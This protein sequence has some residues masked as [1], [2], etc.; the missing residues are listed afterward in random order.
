MAGLRFLEGV[1]GRV[2]T[3]FSI[4]KKLLR[5]SPAPSS[6][7]ALSLVTLPADV[8][9]MIL[10]L[11][12]DPWVCE[13]ERE[14]YDH[15]ICKGRFLLPLSESC[16]YMRR[17]TLP[18]IFREVYNWD[19]QDGSVW[20]ETLWSF[21]LTVHIRDRSMRDPG[22]ITLSTAMFCAL[23][24]MPSLTK[25]TLRL[26][27]AISPEL[28]L[29]LS[30]AP[31][32]TF[33]DIHQVRF[34][35]PA[36]TSSLP[37]ATLE[38]LGISISGFR[39]VL[40]REM[41]NIDRNRQA[42]NVI[43]FLQ[44]LNRS[45]TVLQ[46]SG[47]LLSPD[48]LSLSWPQLRRFTVTEHTPTPYIPV[49]DLV[50]QMPLLTE[51][52]ILFSADLS[53]DRDAG[54]IFPPFIL[55]TP[56]GELLTHRSP[57]LSSVTLSN[58]EPTDPIFAQLPRALESLHLLAM[59]D[60]YL[61]VRG[62]P[63]RL[64][65]ALLTHTTAP[66]ALDNVSHLTELRELSLTLDDFTTA[67]LIHCIASVFPRLRVL[68]LGNSSYLYGPKFCFD[69]RDPTILEA[70]KGFPLLTDLRISLNFMDRELD[71]EG[72]QRHAAHW[73]LEGL[74]GL[75]TVAF[76]WEQKW[77]YYGFN[78]VTWRAWDRTVLL[79]PPSPPPPEPSLV[80]EPIDRD[81]IPPW[82]QTDSE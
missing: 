72:V 33:L 75:L 79:R 67:A 37:F 80:E 29:A 3:V 81:P 36:P 62:R 23:P 24:M 28:L 51:L 56:G 53:R 58:M 11:L 12:Y 69:V 18:W 30:I 76:S 38:T 64:W 17:Q 71:G 32:L 22:T 40:G 5:L 77:W 4:L 45:L 48:F 2:H 15:E 52:S 31:R 6:H 27:A 16:R 35:G 70:L 9:H 74:L 63:A 68:E 61:P 54:D 14:R 73:M 78:M 49:P 66:A 50:S 39:G 44:N 8:L 1:F 59:V 7:A 19:R 82:E 26:E 20:P 13:E 25:I 34:D 43:A 42:R 46:I 57:L 21:F 55:G 47:D 65:A 10:E 60:G 41:L